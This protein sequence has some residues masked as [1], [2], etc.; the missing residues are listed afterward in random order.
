MRL[1]FG[2]ELTKDIKDHIAHAVAPFQKSP[3]GWE[4]PHDYHLTL[5][6]IGETP[7]EEIPALHEE[8][9]K[10]SFPTFKLTLKNFDF[11]SRRVMYLRCELP[12]EIA[13]LAKPGIKEFI[14]HI[15]VK[16]WQRYEYDELKK[17][18]EANPFE[19]KSIEVDHLAL[20]KS[21]KDS[22]NR[23]YHVL[24]KFYSTPT[25]SSTS[26]ISVAR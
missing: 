15:T 24:E 26:I 25:K 5:V 8:L 19:V 9:K 18:L 6:F 7:L 12:D 1:F 2:I 21:E 4:N 14:P 20:F 13:K 3:K 23:K 11:F 10:I 17:K 16:R 22:D